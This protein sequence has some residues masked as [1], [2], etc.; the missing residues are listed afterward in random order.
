MIK[1][2][3]TIQVWNNA[4]AAHSG[5]ADTCG[6]KTKKNKETN[7]LKNKYSFY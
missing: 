3:S 5:G 6:S 2:T 1:Y 7:K 4:E